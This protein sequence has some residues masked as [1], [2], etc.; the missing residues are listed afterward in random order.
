MQ[1][2]TDLKDFDELFWAI[3]VPYQS[4]LPMRG[5]QDDKRQTDDVIISHGW[6]KGVISRQLWN[7]QGF[8]ISFKRLWGTHSTQGKSRWIFGNRPRLLITR[9]SKVIYDKIPR[10]CAARIPITVGHNRGHPRSWPP[11][12]YTGC[13]KK[14]YPPEDHAQ[15][16]PRFCNPSSLYNDCM[17]CT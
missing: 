7:H 3:W 12:H 4:I 14:K 6:I 16:V 17:T 15:L 11:L 8:R 13:E 2:T 9:N 1:H 5:K 10:Y